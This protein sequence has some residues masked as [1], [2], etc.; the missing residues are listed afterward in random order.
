MTNKTDFKRFSRAAVFHGPSDGLQLSQYPIPALTSGEAIVQVELCTLCGSDLH[1]LSGRR[2][3]VTPT[4][5]GHEILGHIEDVGAPAPFDVYGVPLSVGDRV[6][7]SI[8]ASCGDCDRCK[9]QLP[10]KCRRLFKYGHALAEGRTG[11]SG[12]LS[13]YILLQRGTAIVKV[14]QGMPAELL[15]PVNCATATVV[16]A[17]QKVESLAG[18]RVLVLGAGMLGLTAVTY[19]RNHNASE[20][21]LCDIDPHRLV[22]AQEFG[23]DQAVCG[24]V[25]L[26]CSEFDLILELSGSA[27]AVEAACQLGSIGAQ[28]L[29]IGSV[30]PGRPVKIDPEKLVRRLQ[31]VHGIHN[32]APQD[33][34]RAV[35]FLETTHQQ[36]PFASLVEKSFPLKEVVKAIDFAEKHKPIRVAIHPR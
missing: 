36:F 31:T 19:A 29:L 34:M 1:T 25:D 8:A 30:K 13:E 32:Y 10:Q 18:K 12:G 17:Y 7:W 33:L 27:D 24:I 35:R 3:E 20:I 9:N 16:A 22:R 11:L 15:C 14:D 21:T 4:I 23:A 26:Q 2:Q 28:I 6:T 5:L